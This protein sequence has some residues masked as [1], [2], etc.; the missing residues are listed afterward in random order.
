MTVR[1]DRKTRFSARDGSMIVLR[2]FSLYGRWIEL[3]SIVN[4]S[5]GVKSADRPLASIITVVNIIRDS[6]NA[7]ANKKRK[8]KRK[9]QKRTR[10]RIAGEGRG[11]AAAQVV[12]LL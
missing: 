6:E 12:D 10:M 8:T 1:L 7:Y 3:L 9:S 2:P 11:R 4:R 5:G